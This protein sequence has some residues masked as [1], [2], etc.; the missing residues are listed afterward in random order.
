MDAD[1]EAGRRF[2][3]TAEI[4]LQAG[5]DKSTVSRALRADP[6]VKEA[7]RKKILSI[8]SKLGYAPNA[9]A[10]SLSTQRSNIVGFIGSETQNY[11]YQE[12]I[13][14][15][16]RQ[17]T[18]ARRQMMLFQVMADGTIDDVVPDVIQYRLSGCIVIPAVAMTPASAKSLKKVGT[19]VV[20]LNRVPVGDACAVL[21]DQAKGAHAIAEFFVKAG[22]DRIA[23]IAGNQ[24]PA[25]IDREHGFRKGL[26][27]FGKDLHAREEGLF[28][29]RDAYNAASKL[30][31]MKRRPDA[32]FA[33]NDMMAFATLEAARVRGIAIPHELSVIGYDNA[34]VATWPGFRLTTIEQPIELM[35]EHALRLILTRS[36]D[37]SLSPETV[38]VEPRLIVRDSARRPQEPSDLSIADHYEEPV[39]RL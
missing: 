36:L 11:W 10:Q 4:S 5:V 32:I 33:A 20:M 7:T 12:N 37:P 13:Q 39:L 38:E 26:A 29:F 1:E 6:R 9:I 23:L 17:I 30:F 28:T 14:T 19:T 8:A 2:P 31:D 3:T 15:L 27:A 35:F 22:H 24:N 18:L 21:Q 25:A 16:A 34:R